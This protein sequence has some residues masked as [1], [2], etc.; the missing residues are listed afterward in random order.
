MDSSRFQRRLNLVSSLI[1]E[2]VCH[3]LPSITLGSWLSILVILHK[4]PEEAT[5]AIKTSFLA[6]SCMCVFVILFL[7]VRR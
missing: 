3:F 7:L 2:H 1:L 4:A 6:F 5:A